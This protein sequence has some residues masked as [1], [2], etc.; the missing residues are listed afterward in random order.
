M[1]DLDYLLNFNKINTWICGH[2]HKNFDFISDEGTRIIGNQKG[3]P[4]DKI[5]DFI[6][7]CIV[8]I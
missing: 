3:K 6:K 1:S 5:I 2:V 4:K 7:N 8:K